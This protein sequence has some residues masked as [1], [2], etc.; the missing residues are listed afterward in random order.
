MLNE[1]YAQQSLTREG[2]VAIFSGFVTDNNYRGFLNCLSG[3]TFMKASSIF[4]AIALAG[5]A[6]AANAN[7]VTNGSFEAP[8]VGYG[9][10]SG[11]ANGG[12]P[13]WTASNGTTEIQNNIQYGGAADGKQY[14]E[15]NS[16]AGNYVYSDP[17]TTLLAGKSYTLSFAYEGRSDAESVG[18]NNKID[19]LWDGNVIQAALVAP[20]L[21]PN[22]WTYFSYTVVAQGND[23]VGFSSLP[24]NNT[25]YGNFIDNVQVTPLPAALFFVLPALAGVFGFSRRKTA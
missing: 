25:S 3:V 2:K 15:L 24:Y 21:S 7:S 17:I 8:N 14:M 16:T 6:T 13:G 10:W 18:G 22:N 5:A 4:F 1:L 12:V 11:I 23:V 20:F 19:V 9:N